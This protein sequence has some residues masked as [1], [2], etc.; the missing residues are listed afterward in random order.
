MQL[1]LFQQAKEVHKEFK[2]ELRKR[3]IQE[4]NPYLGPKTIQKA[5]K[6]LVN[7]GSKKSHLTTNDLNWCVCLSHHLKRYGRLTVNQYKVIADI[8]KRFK[9]S[10]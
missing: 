1:D 8:E 6:K 7:L 2:E 3:G 5:I 4:K 9:L 10:F